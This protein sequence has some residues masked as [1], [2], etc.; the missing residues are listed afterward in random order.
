QT[1]YRTTGDGR[2]APIG[3]TADLSVYEHP[4]F[5]LQGGSPDELRIPPES[6]AGW[7]RPVTSSYYKRDDGDRRWDVVGTYDPACLPGFDA[8]SRAG[9]ETYAA[10]Q[11]ML[12][13]GRTVGPDRSVGGYVASPPLIL[14]NIAGAN[15]LMDDKR[16]TG[17]NSAAPISSVRIRVRSLP[18]NFEQAQAR[19]EQVA[20][21]IRDRTGLNVDLVRGS[22]PQTVPLELELGDSL[23]PA[24]EVWTK[25]GVVIAFDRALTLQTLALLVQAASLGAMLTM[26]TGFTAVRR[27]RRELGMLR[28]LGWS[29]FDSF[30]LVLYEL[31]IL[32]GL[33][34]LASLVALLIARRFGLQAPNYVLAGPAVGLV[35]ALAGG[36]HSGSRLLLG[37]LEMWRAFRVEAASSAILVGAGALTVAAVAAAANAF[38]KHLDS[39]WLGFYLGGQVRPFHVILAV[40]AAV[41][42]ALAATQLTMLAYLER[43]QTLAALRATG[44]SRFDVLVFIVGGGLLI[45]LPGVLLAAAGIALVG[46]VTGM[47]ASALALPLEVATGT[48][49]ACG[50]LAI[51]GP[52]ALALRSAPAALLRGE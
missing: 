39:S 33:A 43:R 28:A 13:D 21:A 48:G 44:W 30:R 7:F 27:R 9:M 29:A 51:V 35:A 32:G 26:Q 3:V 22:S 6:R 36:R 45:S 19:L 16:F 23:Y 2:L 24:T 12:D 52:A 20:V 31:V 34:A 42:A 18:T 11:V 4:N 49:L 40:T 5:N 1:S 37:A 46:F 41:I 47:S 14:T 15:W 8:L 50:L 25:K 10:P 38:L 17:Q